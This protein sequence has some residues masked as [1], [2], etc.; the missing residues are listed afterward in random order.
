MKRAYDRT[1]VGPTVR[2]NPRPH[3]NTM[4]KRM[5]KHLAAHLPGEKQATALLHLCA[6]APRCSLL[7]R[8]ARAEAPRLDI[9]GFAG[10]QG[11]LAGEALP[12]G[13]EVRR[14]DVGR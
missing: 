9:R 5:T 6:W 3:A 4:R 11:V 10:R 13:E 14:D 2:S 1:F 8:D 7:R 12:E